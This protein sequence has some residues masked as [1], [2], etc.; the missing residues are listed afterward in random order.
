MNI[1]KR[2]LASVLLF[3]F[4]F[5]AFADKKETVEQN[6]PNDQELQ[7][8]YVFMEGVRCKILGDLKSAIACFDQCMKLDKGSAAVRYELASILALGDDLTLPLQLMREAVELDT[9]NIWYK[10]LLANILQKKSMIDEACAVY[11]E[12]ITQHPDREDFYVI[13]TNLY[14]SVEKWGKAIE[15][16]DRHEKQFGLNEAVVI[17]K[18]KLYA[19]LKDVKKASAELMKLVK[20]YPEKTDYL[21]LLAELYLSNDEEKKGLQVLQRVVKSEPD[22]GFAQLFMA[23]Y[24]RSKGDTTEADKLLR[25]VLVNDR[26]DNGLKVQYLLKLLVNQKELQ[27]PVEKIYAYEQILLQRYPE[28]LSVRTLNADF[29]KRMNQLDLCLDELEFLVSKEPGNFLVWEELLLM[30]NQLQDTAAMYDKGLECLRYF[31]NESLPYMAVS[32]PLLLRGETDSAL[33]YLKKGLELAEDGTVIKSQFYSYLGDCY[34]EQDSVDLA[35]SMYDEALK[36]NPNDVLVLNNYSY[37]LALRGERL[38]EAEEMISKAVSMNPGNGTFLDTYA[39]VLFKR[40]DYS[41]AKFYIRSALEDK[42]SV[43]AVMYEHYG[44]ILYMNGEKEEAV[45]MWQ[46]ALKMGGDV[47]KDDLVNKIEN[48]LPTDDE[49]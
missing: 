24:F 34:Y 26:V 30:Y 47:N 32:L 35:F 2:L 17:D 7:F 42:E 21:G 28:D 33:P 19:Q 5:D 40:K 6:M 4:A 15:I 3:L 23:D 38:E 13:E 14:T 22:N 43:S 20:A 45:K 8:N 9:E 41:L 46:M 25:N 1:V 48:G 37:F 44:D 49:E 27:L 10:L 36:I 39:W 16:L 29:L 11:D 31:P 12:L 18:A